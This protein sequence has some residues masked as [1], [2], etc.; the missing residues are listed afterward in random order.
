[1]IEIDK[2]DW[3][4]HFVCDVCGEPIEFGGGVPS[5]SGIVIFYP[6]TLPQF[7]IVHKVK[8]DPRYNRENDFSCW[9]PLDTFIEELTNSLETEEEI[10]A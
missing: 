3:Q 4:A 7:R 1:M 10:T 9:T 5:Q 6:E 8:C 2:K